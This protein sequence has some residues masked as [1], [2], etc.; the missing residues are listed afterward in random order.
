MTKPRFKKNYK[1]ENNCEF[2]IHVMVIKLNIS[3]GLFNKLKILKNK[4]ILKS[5]LWIIMQTIA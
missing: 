5:E 1:T 2:K 3:S 4:T